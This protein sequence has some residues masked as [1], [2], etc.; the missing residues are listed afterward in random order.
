MAYSVPMPTSLCSLP[1]LVS[2][3]LALSASLPV[4]AT[5]SLA[6]QAVPKD[7]QTS[8]LLSAR[9]QYYNLRAAGVRSYTCQVNFDWNGFF[10]AV[11]GKPLPAD[12][13]T[14]VYLN[15]LKV[16]LTNDLSNPA[17][18]KFTPSAAVPEGKQQS[19]DKLQGSIKE[20]VSGF[21]QA[22][23]P[24]LNGTL[25]PEAPSS[26]TKTAGG[27]IVHDA[28]GDG[29]DETLDGSLRVT[30]LI[31]KS[32]DVASTM[33]TT[34]TPS[35]KGLLLTQMEGTYS[36]PASA[37][38]TAVAMKA[39][40]QPFGGFQLPATLAVTIPNVASFNFTFTACTVQR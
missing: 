13:P 8:L 34:F 2:F 31:V 38:P 7:K 27:Y 40:F 20:M 14:M 1:R 24:T 16:Q 19:L 15:G 4:L 39:T 18:I 17:D 10:T 30:S 23:S 36:Q 21:T 12:D 26:M 33:R 3:A 11:A 37:P 9:E 32:E 28:T 6:A 29:T 35:P 22:W 5:T 25:I